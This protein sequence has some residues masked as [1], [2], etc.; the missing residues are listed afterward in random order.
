LCRFL[1]EL[2]CLVEGVLCSWQRSPDLKTQ[3]IPPF[4]S[5][6]VSSKAGANGTF[7]ISVRPSNLT[8]VPNYCGILL[9]AYMTMD[10]AA[11]PSAMGRFPPTGYNGTLF[12]PVASCDTGA[13]L[14][15]TSGAEK[16]WASANFVYR[17]SMTGLHSFDLAVVFD[18]EMSGMKR[19]HGA[20]GL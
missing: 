9:V 12:A 11:T 14:T 5:H 4:P 6:S 20:R 1:A 10:G 15:Q 7:I 8:I 19:R 16:E 13:A 2:V 3:R 18:M 17:P